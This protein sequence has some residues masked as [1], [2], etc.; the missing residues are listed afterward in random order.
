MSAQECLFTDLPVEMCACPQHLRKPE[1]AP[2]APASTLRLRVSGDF[3]QLWAMSVT[4]TD[5]EHHCQRALRG[6]TVD[7]LGPRTPR[8]RWL[9]LEMPRPAGLIG[10]YVCAVSVWSRLEDNAHL[11]AL[12]SPGATAH[13]KWGWGEAFLTDA[14]AVPVVPDYIDP[15]H[16][17]A[18][19]KKFATCRNWQAAWMIKEGLV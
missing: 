12:P 10:W 17:R 11:F 6:P 15:R 14:R 4:G 18:N 13:L 7:G 3:W 19:E 9:E 2:D 1:P 5:L 8:N 16:P